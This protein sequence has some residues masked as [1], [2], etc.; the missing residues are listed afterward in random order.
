MVYLYSCS[1][2]FFYTTKV[3]IATVFS[4]TCKSKGT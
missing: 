1:V 2:C 4:I 3:S